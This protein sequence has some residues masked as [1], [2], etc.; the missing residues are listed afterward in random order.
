MFLTNVQRSGP[1]T[2]RIKRAL[3]LKSSISRLGPRGQG[4]ANH[5]GWEADMAVDIPWNPIPFI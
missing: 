2:M 4:P 3:L 5:V 1:E